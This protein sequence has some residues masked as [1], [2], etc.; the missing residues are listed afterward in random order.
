MNS[1][2]CWDE[3]YRRHSRG[4]RGFLAARLRCEET[5]AELAQEAFARLLALPAAAVRN[6]VGLIYGIAHNLAVDHFRASSRQ[7]TES[8]L[9]D[10][11]ELPSAAPDPAELAQLRQRLALVEEAL[12]RLPAQCRRAFVLN[13]FEGLSQAEV[14]ERMGISRQMA[15]R[16][17]AKALLYLRERLARSA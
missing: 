6:P 8:G 5:A 17:V 4:L 2:S 15:E 16:H 12:A 14:A 11:E 10:A 3:L 9:D 7:Q 13:R 1:T